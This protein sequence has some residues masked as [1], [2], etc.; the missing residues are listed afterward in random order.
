MSMVDLP[1][2]G[3]MDKIKYGKLL[4]DEELMICSYTDNTK[5][6]YGS[7]R[8]ANF[9]DLAFDDRSREE[10]LE[11]FREVRSKG[12]ARLI[13]L[14]RDRYEQPR[15]ID[16]RGKAV[17]G[18]DSFYGLAFWDITNVETA[19]FF[20]YEHL[21]EYRMML[22]MSDITCF[23]YNMDTGNISIFRYVTRKSIRIYLNPFEQF[24]EDIHALSDQDPK[25]MAAVD[26][27]CN[28]LREGANSLDLTIKTCLLHKDKQMQKLKF[29]ARYDTMNQHHIMYGIVINMSTT[30]ED[31]PYYMTAAGLD[32]MTGLLNKR[33]L[34][35]YTEDTLMN[36]ANSNRIHYMV[37][38]DIDDFKRINDNLGHQA[39]DRAIQILATTLTD[40][41]NDLGIIGRFGGDEFYILTDRISDEEG[42]RRMLRAIRTTAAR[43][44]KEALGLDNF[45]LSM[46][47]ALYP[48]V[49][50]TYKELFTIADKCMYIAKEKGKNR[51]I[52]YRPEMHENHPTGS[53]Q[54]GTSSYDEQAKAIHHAIHDLFHNRAA[55]I[56]D[57]LRMIIKGFD[58]DSIDV[59]YGEGMEA[60]YTMGKYPT[61][62]T[63]GDFLSEPK[64]MELYD[65]TGLYVMGNLNNHKNSLPHMFHLFQ[66]KHCMS[67]IQLAL[68]NPVSPRYLISFNML[69]RIHK[70][71][72]SEISNLNLFGS[73]VYDTLQAEKG[74]AK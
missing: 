39:G 12:E 55:A 28:Q 3:D 23:D 41:V 65:E 57:A 2:P 44:V 51:Y 52:I 37:L 9:L 71:S 58:L 15:L 45:T 49:G 74:A 56:P 48:N 10:Y 66:E 22:G 64:Y 29:R 61:G 42:L 7:I 54:K 30:E 13:T 43:R 32:P 17:P 59:F 67:L 69:N 68:P 31:V 21:W 11:F 34:V 19:F 8:K 40:T 20:A 35:E 27:L 6:F 24:V 72:D 53:Q 16:L 5:E 46:G 70:W 62:F 73:L 33:S 50:R 1:I 25:N 60:L 63:A 26:Q 36:P 18:E 4:L 38:L 14:T 47:V